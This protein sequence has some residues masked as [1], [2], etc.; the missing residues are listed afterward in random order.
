MRNRKIA[1]A[2]AF[3]LG[4]FGVHRFYLGQV[5]RG[6]IYAVFFTTLVPTFLGI[7]DAIVFMGMSDEEF[8]RRYNKEARK[9]RND[10]HYDRKYNEKN[11]KAE[12]EQQQR[13]RETTINRRSRRK[14][15]INTEKGTAAAYKKEGIRLYKEFSYEKAIEQFEKSLTLNSRDLTLHFNLSCAYSLTENVPKAMEHIYH[16]VALGYKDFD[17]IGTHEALSYLRI[18]PKYE[19]FRESKYKILPVFEK[20]TKEEIMSQEGVEIKNVTML[21]PPDDSPDLLEELRQ[22]ERLKVLGVLTEK[23]FEEQRKTLYNK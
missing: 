1:I 22:L 20:T 9:A 14:T 19:E 5:F 12:E 18:H 15:V 23:E 13:H 10:V 7:I 16:A 4:T 17:R 3:F 11:Y 21:D 2:L 6:V 8:D